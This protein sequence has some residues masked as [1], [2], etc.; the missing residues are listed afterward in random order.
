MHET[1]VTSTN[2][3]RNPDHFSIRRLL[4]FSPRFSR[5]GFELGSVHFTKFNWPFSNPK[6]ISVASQQS[7]FSNSPS[8]KSTKKSA[9]RF[10]ACVECQSVRP[11][12]V[13]LFTC[14]YCLVCLFTCF[15]ALFV[16]CCFFNRRGMIDGLNIN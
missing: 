5:W 14:F 15:I 4:L 7:M 1:A 12:F 2:H 9:Q 6:F 16:C 13:C 8:L 10:F 11:L 3:L